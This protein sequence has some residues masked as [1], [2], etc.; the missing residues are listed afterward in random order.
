NN[1][2]AYQIYLLARNS[3]ITTNMT[4]PSKAEMVERLCRHAIELDPNYARAWAML[5]IAQRAQAYAGKEGNHGIEAAER[6]LQLDPTV[7]EAHGARIGALISA[8]KYAEARTE[9]DAALALDAD[10][11][12]VHKEAARLAFREHRYTDAV[13]HYEQNAASMETDFSAV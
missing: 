1:L 12:E 2:E 13:R 4:D 7:V 3:Y 8:K 9:I 11:Y 5:A 10:S 6:A